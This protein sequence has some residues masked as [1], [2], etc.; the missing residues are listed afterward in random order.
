[1]KEREKKREVIGI[2]SI[3][4]GEKGEGIYFYVSKWNL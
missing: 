1:M 4:F 3:L 2:I